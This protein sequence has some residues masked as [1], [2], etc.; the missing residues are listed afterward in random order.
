LWFCLDSRDEWIGDSDTAQTIFL[1]LSLYPIRAWINNVAMMH[2]WYNSYTLQVNGAPFAALHAFFCYSA[3]MMMMASDGIK[4][5]LTTPEC[6]L[7]IGATEIEGVNPLFFVLP[8]GRTTR[9]FFYLSPSTSL[10]AFHSY[11]SSIHL[12]CKRE[13]ERER[14]RERE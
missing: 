1:I 7:S 11:S 4:A 14:A 3:M 9:F 13:R 5:R 10:I 8:A 12:C 6:L 2:L